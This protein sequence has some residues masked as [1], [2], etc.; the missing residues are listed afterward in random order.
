V[1]AG[2]VLAPVFPTGLAWLA[3]VLPTVRGGVT[4]LLGSA[5][6]GGAIIPPLIGQ[7]VALT[8][9]GIIPVLLT[10][11]ALAATALAMLLRRSSPTPA[12]GPDHG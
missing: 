2:L 9:P 6:I 8:D 7:I 3:Q 11:V 1:A 10:A 5:L 12:T 4:M